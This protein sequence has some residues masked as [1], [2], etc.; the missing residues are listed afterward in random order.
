MVTIAYDERPQHAPGPGHDNHTDAL[1]TPPP[2]CSRTKILDLYPRFLLRPL[3]PPTTGYQHGDQAMFH[4][5]DELS[6]AQ[7]S[8]PFR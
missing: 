4:F 3:G 8:L 6:K 2:G 1:R 5:Q 7:P